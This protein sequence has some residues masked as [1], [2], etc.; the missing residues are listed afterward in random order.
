MS[1]PSTLARRIQHDKLTTEE[2][3]IK[4][5]IGMVEDMGAHPHLTDAVI[6]L[7]KAANHVADFVDK[8]PRKS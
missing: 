6:A 3:A 5:A 2:K 1:L 8:V 7:N 4:I